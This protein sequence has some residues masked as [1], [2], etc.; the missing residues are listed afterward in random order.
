MCA[1]LHSVHNI[2]SDCVPQLSLSM[3]VYGYTECV[4]HS[5]IAVIKQ[6][7]KRQL[8]LNKDPNKSKHNRP[9]KDRE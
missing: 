9:N 5:F 1:S 4:S 8:C 2:V 7:D 3:D 6:T